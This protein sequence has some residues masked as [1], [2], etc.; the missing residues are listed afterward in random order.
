MIDKF[1]VQ[2]YPLWALVVIRSQHEPLVCRVVGW[3]DAGN[4]RVAPVVDFGTHPAPVA[5]HDL[6]ELHD[7]KEEAH[8]RGPVL[9][10]VSRRLDA[11]E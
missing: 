11:R 7:S 8:K 5:E 2:P 1:T 3:S 4:G 6:V 9:V 10:E